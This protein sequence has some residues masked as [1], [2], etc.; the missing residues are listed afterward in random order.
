MQI[1]VSPNYRRQGIAQRMTEA[2]I[3]MAASHLCMVTLEVRL[4]NHAARALYA[5]LGFEEDGVRKNYYSPDANGCR[6]DAVLM[7]KHI[8]GSDS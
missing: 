3:T 4:S 7:A 8:V 5:G 1:A 6:E 2:L